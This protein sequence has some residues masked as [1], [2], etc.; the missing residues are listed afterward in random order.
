MI[1][2]MAGR[3]LAYYVFRGDSHFYHE[4]HY[5]IYKIAYLVYGFLF[6][7]ALSGN[8]YFRRLLADFFEYFVYTLFKKIGRV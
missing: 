5:M 2:N 1:Y 6:V 4:H 3:K 8:Y 7:S